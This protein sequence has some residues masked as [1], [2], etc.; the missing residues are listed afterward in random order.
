MRTA[1]AVSQRRL[2][3][4]LLTSYLTPESRMMIRRN[5]RRRLDALA[6]FLSWD[7]DPYLVLTNDGRLVWIVDGYMTSQVHPYSREIGLEGIGTFNYI[8]NSVKATVDA[9]N[10]TIHLYVF[11]PDDPLLQAYRNLFPDLFEPASAMPAELRAHV[12]Y[13]ATI[14]AAQAEIYRL[15]HMR[16]PDTFYNKSDAWDIPKFT[17]EQNGQPT[18]VVP[19]YVVATLPGETKPEFLL[20]I[21]FTPR[22]RDNLIGL[23]MARCD[24]EHLGEK[25]VLLLSKQEIIY[26][27]MQVEARINQDQNISKDLTLWNQQ[28]SQVL[29]GQMLVLPIEH[30]SFFGQ[31]FG[32]TEHDLESY[33]VRGA[34]RRRRLR[35]PVLRI[36]GHQPAEHRRIHREERRAGRVPGR[37]R[38]RDFGR[39][40]R[41]CL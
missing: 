30:T 24:G 23:M 41:L 29:R 12:R 37:G 19:S 39:A 28:G 17:S 36:P 16:D 40:D 9:Y 6:D 1:A 7:V 8:R 3:R 20:M 2:E 11:D 21:P 13:P 22:T 31:K 15:F 14:F 4:I 26:G 33:L 18:P 10:G 5:V 32:I 25:V 38:A 34:G 27:P 35:G